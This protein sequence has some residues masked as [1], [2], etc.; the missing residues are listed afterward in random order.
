M[1]EESGAPPYFTASSDPLPCIEIRSAA[2]FMFFLEHK[3]GCPPNARWV[4]MWRFMWPLTGLSARYAFIMPSRN[5]DTGNPPS[6][7]PGAK[8]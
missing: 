7:L 1:G 4:C 8:H 3:T 2:I 6:T 5:R